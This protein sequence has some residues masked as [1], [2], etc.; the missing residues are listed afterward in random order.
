PIEGGV[1]VGA[2]Q[3]LMEGGDQVVVLFAV[4]VIE[5]GA[6]GQQF[7]QGGGIEGGRVGG[8]GDDLLDHIQQ[9]AA[10]AIGHRSEGGF[11]VV[12]EGERAADLCLR[13][14]QE[15]F[16]SGVVKT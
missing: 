4:L 7:G 10:V 8:E 9:I 6:A 1:G 14:G 15:T 12:G 16:Q 13:R 5:G 3:R 2:S 11:R